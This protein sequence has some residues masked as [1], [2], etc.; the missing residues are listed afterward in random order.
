MYLLIV[1][2]IAISFVILIKHIVY[3]RYTTF[4]SC[5]P[6][7]LTIDKI[8]GSRVPES[9]VSKTLGFDTVNIKFDKELPCGYYTCQYLNNLV[10]IVIGKRDLTN[11]HVHFDRF[12][13]KLD[14]IVRFD[15][16]N[17][18]KVIDFTNEMITTYNEGCCC[19]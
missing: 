4:L 13:E 12:D 14:K 10:T 5:N 1:V 8:S 6:T 3:D 16:V 17:L 11:G 2:L 19:K 15:F 18:T 9:G 7:D